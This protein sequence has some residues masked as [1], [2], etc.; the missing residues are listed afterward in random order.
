MTRIPGRESIIH[1]G[2]VLLATWVKGA[3]SFVMA[4][5]SG[6][7]LLFFSCVECL[8]HNPFARCPLFLKVNEHFE[9]LTCELIRW[10]FKHINELVRLSI[11]FT[12]LHLRTRCHSWFGW[13]HTRNRPHR[14]LPRMETRSLSTRFT[15]RP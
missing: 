15:N 11:E 13:M 9:S 4:V 14:Q 8:F 3:L 7:S 10:E 1:R 12:R 6:F 5:L 2:R